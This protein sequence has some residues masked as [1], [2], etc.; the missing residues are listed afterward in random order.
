M[1]RTLMI[2]AL[3]FGLATT[4][5]AFENDTVIDDPVLE[6]RAVALA[7]ELRCLVCQNQ[8]IMESD[9]DLARDLRQIVREQVAAGKS[10]NDIKDYVVERYGDFVLLRPPLKSTTW[11]LWFGPPLIVGGALIGFVMYWRRRATVTAAAPNA[12]AP[13]SAAERKRLDALLG[14]GSDA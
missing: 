13:L 12:P 3:V 6:A 9:A 5:M 11:V 7:K 8:S 1:I 2:A 10:D 14:D 4:V